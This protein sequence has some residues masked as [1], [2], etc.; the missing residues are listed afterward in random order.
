[1]KSLL[2]LHLDKLP[3]REI[4]PPGEEY[5]LQIMKGSLKP[6]KN[7]S[8]D[9]VHVALKILDH[10]T[11]PPVMETL[12]IPIDSD[13]EDLQF[14]FQDALRNFFVAFS[15]DLVNPWESLI[16][17]TEGENKVKVFPDWKGQEGWANL[18]SDTYE[19]RQKNV[20][21]RYIKKG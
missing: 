1:M 18:G 8:R 21:S 10:P 14:N 15:I 3:E 4:V 16:E 5:Q 11:A 20:V 13:S 2:A 19:G 6:S 7:S 9:V 12:C 17:V